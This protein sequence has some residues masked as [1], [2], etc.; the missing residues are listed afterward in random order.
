MAGCSD[1]HS[2]PYG[3][4]TCNS[5]D[6]IYSDVC[7]GTV[8]RDGDD[9][10]YSGVDDYECDRTAIVKDVV[11]LMPL[12]LITVMVV[13]RILTRRTLILKA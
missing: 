10:H 8:D 2:R 5:D 3:R 13:I 4:R 7:G 12:I 9:N 6:D 11:M 1:T